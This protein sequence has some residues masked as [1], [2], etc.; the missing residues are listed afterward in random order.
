MALALKAQTMSKT[1]IETF[2]DGVFSIVLTLLVFNF[3]VPV[4]SGPN[5]DHELYIKLLAMH[6]YFITY[7]LSFVLISMFW[8][9]H[10]SL[11]HSLKHSNV[12]LL[13]LNNLFLL[14][15][16]ILP[17]PTQVLGAYPNTES[18]AIFFGAVMI[19]T[20]LTFSLLRYYAFFHGKL[21]EDFV[22]PHHMRANLRK[23]IIVAGLYTLALAISAYSPDI[24]L[25]LYALIPFLFFVPLRIKR[26]GKTP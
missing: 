17:F 15:L 5:F 4:L 2:S 7:I 16:A 26:K 24:T 13:W 9:A 10:H 12:G 14:C 23:G 11:F 21:A 25:S 19:M 1:R 18:A 22:S 8:I 20:S 6:P 3:K